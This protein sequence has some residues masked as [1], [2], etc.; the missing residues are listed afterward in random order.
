MQQYTGSFNKKG[1]YSAGIHRKS[2]SET[3]MTQYLVGE[4]IK[5]QGYY[6][7]ILFFK[8]F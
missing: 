4:D 7:V 3:L 6:L 5:A 1:L 2:S 8:I